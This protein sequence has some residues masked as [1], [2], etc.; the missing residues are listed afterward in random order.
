MYW[1]SWP[2]EMKTL[3]H[4]LTT[5]GRLRADGVYPLRLNPTTIRRVNLKWSSR[6]GYYIK[7]KNISQYSVTNKRPLCWHFMRPT[8]TCFREKWCIAFPGGDAIYNVSMP[9]C[10]ES[11]LSTFWM[12]LCHEKLHVYE[13]CN[14]L[15]NRTCQN[16]I[17]SHNA[18]HITMKEECSSQLQHH[19]VSTALQ[20]N[21]A[22]TK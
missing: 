12:V 4:T 10:L 19:K 21:F 17:G 8:K 3:T 20:T 13:Q 6:L 22:N 15:I 9:R 11:T 1:S 14:N 16:S 2:D 7:K 18:L 5:N